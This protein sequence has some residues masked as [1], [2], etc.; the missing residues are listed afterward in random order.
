MV[1]II[2]HSIM[3][4]ERGN[5]TDTIKVRKITKKLP[6]VS[7]REQG[8]LQ[9]VFVLVLDLLQLHAEFLDCAERQT[10]GGQAVVLLI[11]ADDGLCAWSQLAVRL[12]SEL[13]TG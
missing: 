8:T 2:R 13:V 5:R 1:D 7:G 6:T 4:S 11:A 12:K 10:A 9:L 3:A